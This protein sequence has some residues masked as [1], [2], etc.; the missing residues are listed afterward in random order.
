[1]MQIVIPYLC[2]LCH[3][4]IVLEVVSLTKCNRSKFIVSLLLNLLIPRDGVIVAHI[5]TVR[6]SD[7]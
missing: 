2:Q 3:L 6:W 5:Y 4:I 7:Y 1:M